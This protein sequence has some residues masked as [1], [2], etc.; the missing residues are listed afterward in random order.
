VISTL[1]EQVIIE[2]PA[3]YNGKYIERD[4]DGF[5]S[6]ILLMKE[7]QGRLKTSGI[8]LAGDWHSERG[9]WGRFGVNLSGTRVLR[10]DRQFGPQE[11]YRSNL[12]VFLNDQVIQKWRHRVSF[13]WDSGPYTLSLANQYSSSYTDQNTTYDPYTDKL[14]PANRVKSYS[15]W[16]LTGSW[17]ITKQLKLRAGVLNLLDTDP[18][19]SNQAYYF[20]AGYDPSY[21]DPRGRSGYVSL[22]YSFK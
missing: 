17:A 11:P 21:T 12:G 6:N 5:I 14:L 19:F 3:A 9:A 22:N 13:D 7:N 16:D 4:E 8:D 2:N 15:L 18:P 1:G 20:L 10:Y